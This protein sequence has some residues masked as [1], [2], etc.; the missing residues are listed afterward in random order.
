MANNPQ[1][2]EFSAVIDL[3]RPRAVRPFEVVEGDTGNRITL[4][5][6]DSGTPVD[7][8]GMY[9]AAVFSS[10]HGVSVQDSEDGSVTISGSTAAIDLLP[11]SV[12]PG[13]I[14]CELQLYSTAEEARD[15]LVTSARFSFSCR[16]AMLC[17][18]AIH[19]L[20]QFPYLTQTLTEIESAE[21]AR[22]AAENTRIS[23]E[24]LRQSREAQRMMNEN[25][26]IS[27]ENQR[28]ANEE[29]RQSAEA[30]RAAAEEERETTF[31][32]IIANAGVGAKVVNSAPTEDTIESVGRIL[33][34]RGA[35]E[36]Y[37]CT[38]SGIH[39]GDMYCIWKR[40]SFESPWV[41]LKTLTLT[42]DRTSILLDEDEHGDTFEYDELEITLIGAMKTSTIAN[43]YVNGS[44]EYI[45]DSTFMNKDV[46]DLTKNMTV[47]QLKKVHDGFA[48]YEKLSSGIT[49][50]S[51]GAAAKAVQE[52]YLK[53]SP[54]TRY[55][56]VNITV[57]NSTSRFAAGTVVK[58]RGRNVVS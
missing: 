15:T 50:S 2:K 57:N 37:I 8:T 33:V 54:E 18:E 31:A 13:L 26:R 58:L 5:L 52:G 41:E 39:A 55:N 7:M 35:N 53:I 10:P 42:S 40:I 25:A 14:E 56:S 36:A 46:A 22:I 28:T 47:I 49:D 27:A 38:G 24:G 21:A 23:N 9:V 30:S 45:K 1:L 4:T 29:Q 44:S 16:R 48:V 20:P 51:G 43:V 12:S 19:A 32:G 6:T 34:V 11:G 3:K 17:E